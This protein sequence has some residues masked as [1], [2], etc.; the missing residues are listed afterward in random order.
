MNLIARYDLLSSKID[1]ARF[2]NQLL[3]IIEQRNT[4]ENGKD[5]SETFDEIRSEIELINSSLTGDSGAETSEIFQAEKQNFL[6][7]I[8]KTER[9][10]E[11]LPRRRNDA[12]PFH[13]SSEKS[14]SANLMRRTSSFDIQTTLV[15]F[16]ESF[17]ELERE[18]RRLETNRW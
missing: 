2:E 16:V 8:E 4:P 3:P 13:D 7:R 11:T 5:F 14:L 10:C 12:D 15:N 6:A 17:D 9:I 1:Y 18:Y